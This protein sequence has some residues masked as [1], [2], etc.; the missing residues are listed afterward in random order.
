M[1]VKSATFFLSTGRCGTQWLAATLGHMFSDVAMVAHEPLRG[2]Y[3]PKQ[4]LRAHHKLHELLHSQEFSSHISNIQDTLRQGKHYIETG[5]PCYPAIPLLV[6]LFRDN[7]KLVHIVRH[8]VYASLSMATHD[9]Y[10]RTD[11]ITSCTIDPFD[12]GVIQK[13]LREQWHKMT[14]YEKLLFWWTEIN[15]YALELK[16]RYPE[17]PYLLVKYEDLFGPSRQ[18]ELESIIQFIGLPNR[19]PQAESFSKVDRFVYRMNYVD[20]K[21]LYK[22]PSTV[23][24]AQHF[25]YDLGAIDSKG[26]KERYF[27]SAFSTA[28]TRRLGRWLRRVGRK[29]CHIPGRKL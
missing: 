28:A 11:W 25:G 1:N 16:E 4:Y 20:W 7:I 14:M 22:Y 18:T 27:Y 26:L 12:D 13:E 21:L 5:W 3:H 29:I 17:V 23:A 15:L 8:P 9:V 10:N 24:L 2:S 6:D 19:N